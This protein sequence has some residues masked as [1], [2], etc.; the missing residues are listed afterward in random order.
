MAVTVHG[1]NIIRRS[2][3]RIYPNLNLNEEKGYVAFYKF[4][5]NIRKIRRKRG[6]KYKRDDENIKED[7]KRGGVKLYGTDVLYENDWTEMVK[8]FP[9]VE[10]ALYIYENSWVPQNLV[11]PEEEFLR[12]YRIMQNESSLQTYILSRG[13]TEMQIYGD[14][15]MKFWMSFL[16]EMEQATSTKTLGIHVLASFINKYGNPFHQG[17]RDL[18]RIEAFNTCVTTPLLAE[19]CCMETI[20]ELNIRMRMR[21]EN[22][23]YLEFGDEKVDPIEL[24]REFFRMC[25]PHPK[26][27]NNSLRAPYSW[28]VKMWG[29][30]AD[31]IVL[32]T[33]DGGDDRNAKDVFFKK[34]KTYKNK[35]VDIFKADFYRRSLRANLD[36]V[37]ETEEYA[38]SLCGVSL[39]LKNFKRMLKNVYKT[40][41]YPDRISNVMLASFLLSIQTISGY[42]RA[43]VVNK[44]TDFEN[45]VKPNKANLIAEVSELTSNYFV[46]AYQEAKDRREEIVKPEDLYTSMLRLARNTSSGFS[47]KIQVEKSFGPGRKDVV[48]IISRIKALVIFTKGHEVFTEKEL[49]K[50]YNTVELYQT[51][52]SRDVPIKSTRTIYSINLSILVPQLIVTLPLNEFFARVGGSTSPDYRKLGG[53]VIVGDLEATGSRVV[54]AIDTFRNSGDD[55][56]FSIAID[57]S[58][59]DTHLT[60]YNFRQGML[61]GIR[62]AM[63]G[64][65]D[66]RYEGYTLDEIVDFG[67]GEGRVANSLWNGKRRVFLTTVDKYLSLTD[68]ERVQGDF[69]IPPGVKPVTNVEIAKRIEIEK[70]DERADPDSYLLISPTDG[71]DLAKIDTHLSGENSTLIANSLHN[72]AIGTLIQET[73]KKKFPMMISFLSEQYVGDDTLLYARLHTYDANNIDMIANTI[74]DVVGK[75]G[76]EA[77]ESKTMLAPFSVEKTQTHAKQGVYIPQDRMMII[78]SERR[79]DIESVQEYV[80]SQVQTSVTKVSRGFSHTL[81]TYILMLKTSVI[82]AWKLKRTI[83]DESRYRD[84]KFDSDDED[85]FTLVLMRNPL[86]LFVPIG[87]NGYGAHPVAL[88]IVMT[89]EIFMDSMIMPD[90]RE[91]MAPIIKILGSIPPPWNETKADKRSI[92]SGTVNSFFGKMARPVVRAALQNTEVM[93]LLETLPLGDYSPGRISRTMMHSA[94]LK[95]PTAR[96]LLTAGYELEYQRD[97]NGWKQNDVAFTIGEGAGLISSAY[98]KIFDVYVAETLPFVKHAFPDQNLSPQ[99]YLQKSILGPRRSE[100]LRMSYIDRLDAILRKDTVMRGFIT[101]N[102]IVNVVEQLGLSHT[103]DDLSMVFMLMN[104]EQ[105][106]AEELASYITSERVRFDALKLVK[107][108]IVGDEFSMSL[109]VSTQEMLEETLIYPRELSKTELDAVSLYVSQYQML[110]ASMGKSKVRLQIHVP[111]DIKRRYKIKA[112]RFRTHVPKLKILR[113][114][115]DVNRMS[116]RTLENQFV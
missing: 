99:F 45:Q 70:A 116:V 64:Y 72:M 79:K 85:G 23:T 16:I 9:V 37:I 103:A 10:D 25:L 105:R 106:V 49:K 8:G 73:V 100:R 78:S 112:Q 115:L 71:S 96:T 58:E 14:V 29:I 62:R 34:F 47:T 52:G 7:I 28:F 98:M 35:Y 76:H 31:P 20:L 4:S 17:N 68:E 19:M 32:L 81:A 36:K 2:L 41:F 109:N 51:K 77:S 75:C 27:I 50:K 69:K 33:S 21:E 104:I 87:W 5:D 39:E 102:T 1:F 22:L 46:Q 26:K 57:Y 83:L 30:A 91:I 90:L 15:P 40:P 38:A 108:G 24:L 13:K 61:D 93:D 74:F 82:G 44:P 43:W 95:E 53:K 65:G 18:S 67:Y 97:L 86:T 66:L 113:K 63:K 6:V 107:K 11:N 3:E 114:L 48:E 56:I 89:E 80:R 101:G 111:D 84:R 60:R 42:G 92:R 88:N 54:D 55:T 94:L 110:R 59:Y 12:N